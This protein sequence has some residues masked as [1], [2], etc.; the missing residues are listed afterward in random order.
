MEI[1][2]LKAEIAATDYQIIKC[3]ECMLLGEPMPYN[4]AELHEQRQA[5]LDAINA[6]EQ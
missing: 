1:S 5:I 3:S 4:V 6:L 2:R